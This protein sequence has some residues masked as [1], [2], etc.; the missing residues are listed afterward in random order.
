MANLY[1]PRDASDLL[2]LV[3]DYPLAW[4][5]SSGGAG[6][7]ATPLPMV[8]EPNAAG[9][10]ASLMGHFAL[11]NPHVEILR[12]TPRALILFSGPQAYISPEHVTRP[13]W[14]PTWNYA[15]ARF[16]V[17]IELLPQANGEALGKLTE[18]MERDRRKP[19][20]I[21]KM[22]ERYGR[23]VGHVMAF[24]A[25]VRSVDATFKLG[26]DETPQTFTEIVTAMPDETLVRWMRDFNPGR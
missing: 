14:A 9:E 1:D 17:D 11:R 25:H 15:V 8:A 12:A 10:I 22:G 19:W 20:T 2:R 23:I 18:Q 5:V 4:I 21:A 24:R 26:Q 6:F 16:E 3:R 13:Q 7:A